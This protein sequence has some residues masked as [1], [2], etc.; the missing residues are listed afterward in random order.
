[1]KGQL[2][3]KTYPSIKNNTL[4][5][6]VYKDDESNVIGSETPLAIIIFSI[7]ECPSFQVSK[8]LY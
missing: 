8:I 5:F 1:M 6:R 2:K 3:H 4:V 7:L